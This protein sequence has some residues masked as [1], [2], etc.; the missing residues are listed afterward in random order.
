MT[1]LERAQTY[2]AIFLSVGDRWRSYVPVDATVKGDS[3]Y[4]QGVHM[5]RRGDVWRLT[6]NVVVTV[7]GAAP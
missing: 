3:V 5:E 1:A 6:E 4:L 2:A 7:V